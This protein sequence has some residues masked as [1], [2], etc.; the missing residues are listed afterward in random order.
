M[1]RLLLL[2]TLLVGG[3][4]ACV[5]ER[6]DENGV[7]YCTVC[8]PPAPLAGPNVDISIR[9]YGDSENRKEVISHGLITFKFSPNPRAA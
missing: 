2:A 9:T 1:I 4:T 5:E 8:P 6:I 3:A 7:I